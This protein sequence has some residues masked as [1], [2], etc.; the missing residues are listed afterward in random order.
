MLNNQIIAKIQ[1]AFVKN[2]VVLIGHAYDNLRASGVVNHDM[3]E[4]TVSENLR[5]LMFCDHYSYEKRI[6]VVREQPTDNGCLLTS[7]QSAN[8][9][10]RIDFQFQKSWSTWNKKQ[11]PLVL[12]MEAKCLYANDF[13]KTGNSSN[14]SANT[15]YKRYVETGIMHLLTGYYPIN[16]CLLGYVL[17]GAVTDA[18]SGINTQISSILSPAEI[19][20]PELPPHPTLYAYASI[21]NQGKVISH[22]ML[23]F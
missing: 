12:F 9:L 8:S 14:T 13:K 18:I 4:N 20:T 1:G 3:N 11:K 2:C 5:R 15:Y 16:T 6:M 10:P 23:Q 17:E 19:L 22:L 21:H 7:N